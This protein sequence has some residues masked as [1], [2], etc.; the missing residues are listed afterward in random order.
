MHLSF[1]EPS[2]PGISSHAQLPSILAEGPRAPPLA[3]I[4]Q[5][6]PRVNLGLQTLGEA[7][8]IQ[9]ASSFPFSPVANDKEYLFFPRY[10]SLG[11]DTQWTSV[12]LFSQSADAFFFLQQRCIWTRET[13]SID[14]SNTIHLAPSARQFV[15][16]SS[17]LHWLCLFPSLYLGQQDNILIARS[18]ERK[19]ESRIKGPDPIAVSV[20]VRLFQPP[21]WWL[22]SQGCSAVSSTAADRD[23]FQTAVHEH[24]IMKSCI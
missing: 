1:P 16:H 10:R 24:A 22:N 23:D 11:Y 6:V 19:C 4:P 17:T 9:P 3:T 15:Q 14:E 12:P 2:K 13:L 20:W 18:W 21:S 5:W 8:A 7:P